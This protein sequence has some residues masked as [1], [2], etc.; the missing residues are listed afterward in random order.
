MIV[1]LIFYVRSICPLLDM[2]ALIS[3]HVVQG[4]LEDNFELIEYRPKEFISTAK[5]RSSYLPWSVTGGTDFFRAKYRGV[6]FEFSDVWLYSERLGRKAQWLILG[7][8]REIPTPLMISGWEPRGEHFSKQ[9]RQERVSGNRIRYAVFTESPDLLPHVL[10]PAFQE[11]LFKPHNSLLYTP[12]KHIFFK[13]AH[14]HFGIG[15]GARGRDFFEPCRNV[16]DIPAFRER[17]QEEIDCIKNI[18]DG[19]LLIEWLFPGAETDGRL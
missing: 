14:A 18:I 6:F 8:H 11:F 3:T 9:A 4:M 10:T 17:V 16:Q 5:V 13:E 12:S 1:G 7:L 15:I 2:R 19:F